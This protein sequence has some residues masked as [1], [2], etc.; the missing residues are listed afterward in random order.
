MQV[1]VVTWRSHGRICVHRVEEIVGYF[2]NF[3]WDSP[4]YSFYQEEEKK[5]HTIELILTY[6]DVLNELHFL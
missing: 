1:H 4:H 6:I 5:C 3:T 2:I